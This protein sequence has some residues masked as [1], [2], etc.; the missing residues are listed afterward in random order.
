MILKVRPGAGLWRARTLSAAAM[1]LFL[2]MLVTG[3]GCSREPEE[4][5]I[6]EGYAR[7]T[8]PALR[9]RLG[10]GSTVI[11]SLKPAEHVVIFQRRRRWVRIRTD[12]R[13][14]GWIDEGNILAPEEYAKFRDEVRATAGKASQGLA[15]ARAVLNLHLEPDR[16]SPAF[17]QLAEGEPCDVIEHRAMAKPPPGAT[18]PLAAEPVPG[19]PGQAQTGEQQN[20][21]PAQT[22]PAEKNPGLPATAKKGRMGRPLKPAGPAMEDWFLV[23][24]KEKA[25]WALAHLVDM[26]IPDEVAQYAEGK[27]ITA[28][29]VLDE[30]PAGD[31]KKAQYLWATSD[32]SGLPY[33]FTGIRVFVWNARHRRYGTSYREHNLRGVYPL[34]VGKVG[35]KR[36]EVPSFTVTT[37][38]D[39]GKRV[40]REFVLLG[41]VVR[42]REQVQ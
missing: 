17:Y 33:D 9:D 20:Q 21:P 38:D 5:P 8:S 36:G 16:K 42:R 3:A 39:A 14:E 22:E 31:Q 41:D 7:A 4:R 6:G 18:P 37:L 34:A 2:F 30:V 26:A 28:W 29:Q 19:Q 23:R 15:R 24:G 40:T 35:L 27:P 32:E 25:G 11:G 10:A 13:R 12:A 1:G